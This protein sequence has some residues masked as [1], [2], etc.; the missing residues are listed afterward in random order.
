M[1]LDRYE[2]VSRDKNYLKTRE[3]VWANDA[4]GPFA[5]MRFGQDRAINQTT[6]LGKQ[7]F[8]GFSSWTMPTENMVRSVLEAGYDLVQ[9]F[10]PLIKH[11]PWLWVC[12][13]GRSRGE[14]IM[15]FNTGECK[16]PTYS[17]RDVPLENPFIWPVSGIES[18]NTAC[19]MRPIRCHGCYYPLMDAAGNVIKFNYHITPGHMGFVATVMGWQFEGKKISAPIARKE[20]VVN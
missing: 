8:G 11:S 20:W 7:L 14:Y 18:A 16:Q 2:R 15:N 6:L 5:D 19:Y 4:F 1:I 17:I 10:F 9:K 12:A 13:T 3:C